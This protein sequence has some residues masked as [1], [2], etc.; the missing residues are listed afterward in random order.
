[1]PLILPCRCQTTRRL[2]VTA[3]TTCQACQALGPR[4]QQ[5]CCRRGAVQRQRSPRRPWLHTARACGASCRARS[6]LQHCTRTSPPSGALPHYV[7]GRQVVAALSGGLVLAADLLK[8]AVCPYVCLQQCMH[9]ACRAVRAVSFSSCAVVPDVLAGGK[10]RQRLT[11]ML[12]R[13]AASARMRCG[14]CWSGL[15]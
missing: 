5:A 12:L 1:M 8:E 10:L 14:R 15:R 3:A 9:A 6:R 2:W 11:L 13:C 7:A 4:Q